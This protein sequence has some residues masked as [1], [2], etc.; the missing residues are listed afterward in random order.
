MENKDRPLGIRNLFQDN[1][2]SAVP[3]SRTPTGDADLQHRLKALELEN[4]HLRNRLNESESERENLRIKLDAQRG[5]VDSLKALQLRVATTNR[6]LS[7]SLEEVRTQKQN[8]DAQKTAELNKRELQLRS[9]A[10]LLVSVKAELVKGCEK[11]AQEIQTAKTLHPLKDYL[12][13][14]QREISRIEP[15]LVKFSYGS[16]ERVPL[17][18]ALKQFIEQRDWLKSLIAASE[19]ELR[20]QAEVVSQLVERNQVEVVVPPPPPRDK[21]GSFSF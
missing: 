1:F 17:E 12:N 3:A 10:A 13:F 15:E 6:D 14:S 7:S 21:S 20:A 16:V 18:N 4:M 11:L 5:L 8:Q 19:R 9:Y 2:E